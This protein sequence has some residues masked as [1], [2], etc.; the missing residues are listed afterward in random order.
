VAVSLPA[1][2]TKHMYFSYGHLIQ[3]EIY[4]MTKVTIFF[5]RSVDSHLHNDAAWHPIN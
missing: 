2:K 3:P 1:K 5:F 4:T